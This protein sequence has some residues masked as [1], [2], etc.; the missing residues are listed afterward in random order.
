MGVISFVTKFAA[1]NVALI[2]IFVGLATNGALKPLAVFMDSYEGSRGTFFKG[3]IPSMHGDEPWGFTLEEIPDLSGETH[4]VTGGNVGL[5]Y[6]TAYHLAANKATVIIGC[7]SQSKCDQAAAS[8]ETETGHSVE[9]VVL[10]LGSFASIRTCAATIAAKHPAL[11]S[12]VLNAGVMVPPFGLTEDGLETQIGVNHFGHFLLTKLL[13][14]QVE[15]AAASKGVATIVPVSSAAHYD[16]Y[17]E[18]IRMSLAEMNDEA[19]YDRALAYGQSKLANVLFAQELAK[20]TKSQNI[21]VNAIH[22]G[23]VDTDL[24]RHVQ[25][26]LAQVS[27]WLAEK[28]VEVTSAA[29]WHPRE[30]ALTQLYAAVGPSLRAN[31]TTGKYFHPIARETT[32]DP[33]ALGDRGAKLGADLWKLSEDFIAKH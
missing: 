20:R 3:M 30:A 9:T 4:F 23:G 6:W 27:T 15:A 26:A 33:H 14:P 32:P 2:A 29:I 18:G 28:F 16:S 24:S 8:I 11:D 19:T 17:P 5:G 7:R 31:K 13:L 21:L 1:L 10:D 12:L 25:A 22:P